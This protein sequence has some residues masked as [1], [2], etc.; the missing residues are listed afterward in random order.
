MKIAL[1]SPYDFAYPGGVITHISHLAEQFSQMGHQVRI[2]SPCSDKAT[3]ETRNVVS[4]GRVVPFFSN[5]STARITF[6]WWQFRQVKSILEE[7]KFDIV[8]F[9]EPFCPFLPWVALP[10]SKSINIGTFHAYYERSLAYWAGKR[11]LLKQLSQ[12]LDGR[13]AVSEPAKRFVSKY[14]PGDYQI[15]PHGIDT[16]RFSPKVPPIERFKDGKINILFVS[17]LDKRK[18]IGYLLQAYQMVKKKMPD[19]R[20][21]IVGPGRKQKDYQKWT[22]EQN[23]K[24]VVFTGHVLEDDLPR[25]YQTG[26]IFCAPAIGKESFGIIL[27]EAMASGKP[28]IASNIEGYANVVSH[29]LDGLLVPPQDNSALA[30]AILFLIA[31]QEIAQQMAH[32][33]REKAEQLSWENIAQRTLDYYLECSKL[34]RG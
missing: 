30:E 34:H 10:L 6:S 29:Q 4:V 14:F 32:R 27:L 26:D 1:V 11:L 7:G 12:K 24:D 23:L 16:E 2:I 33:G 17:R 25:Y 5:D 22:E 8:H 19:T 3:A 15:I 21:I 31:H 9:H 18:G 13:I 20:L 28:I